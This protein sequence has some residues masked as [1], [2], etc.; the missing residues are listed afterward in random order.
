MRKWLHGL[1]TGMIALGLLVGPL[2]AKTYKDFKSGQEVK[3]EKTKAKSGIRTEKSDQPWLG[4]YMQSV[5]DEIA[6]AFDLDVTS[7]VVINEIVEGSPAEQAGLQ[8]DDIITRLNGKQI[9]NTDRL[10][11][12]L[13]DYSPGD[14]VTLT[15]VRSSDDRSEMS[16]RDVAVVLGDR[17]NEDDDVSALD[18][19][20]GN[21]NNYSYNFD[22]R[23]QER[24]YL[25]VNLMDINDQLGEYFGVARGEGALISEVVEDS[26]AEK[27]GLKAGDV[28]TKIGDDDIEDADD[29]SDIVGD[30]KKDEAVTI[31]V[32]RD[33]RALEI[34]ATIDEREND[35]YSYF[36]SPNFHRNFPHVMQI[37]DVP[38]VPDVQYFDSRSSRRDMRNFNRS[39]DEFR[40]QM[41]QL[42][43]E[44]EELR[45]KI[46]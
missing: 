17:V 28:I 37:P 18:D 10:V 7:G 11:S 8:E 12:A 5:T 27:A 31:T 34:Q 20:R 25:G 13:S 36:F 9:R 24:G 19:D 4:V 35:D 38:P 44:M 30:L 39:M 42:K 46:D 41:E 33:K 14:K 26:P 21:R 16:V 22:W 2:G 6:E 29:V 32:I 40:Q 1:L 43:K 15:I 3:E 45:E 23:G